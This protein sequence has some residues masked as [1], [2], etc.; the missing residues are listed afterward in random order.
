MIKQELLADG[1]HQTKKTNRSQLEN[2]GAATHFC[3]SKMTISVLTT[4]LGFL[5]LWRYKFCCR[6]CITD[7]SCRRTKHLEKTNLPQ[8]YQSL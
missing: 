1:Q 7:S 3:I 6:Q 4:V 2:M 8:K 5:Q